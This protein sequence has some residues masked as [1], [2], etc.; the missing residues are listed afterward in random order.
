M[1][2]ADTAGIDVIEDAARA[3]RALYDGR[4]VGSLGRVGCFS[5]YPGK[6]VGAYG[7]GGAV[8]TDDDTIAADTSMFRDHGRIEGL[9]HGAVSY[10]E[11]LDGLRAAI[12]RTKLGHLEEWNSSRRRIAPQYSELLED[13]PAVFPVRPLEGTEPVHHL[14]VIRVEEGSRDEL[15]QYLFERGVMAGV[16]YKI[17]LHQTTALKG[18]GYQPGDFPV[19]EEA[20]GKI[21][22]LPIFPEMSVDQ[23]EYVINSVREYL[24]SI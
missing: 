20:A 4:R 14:Y 22:S 16:H 3:H 5:F 12:L 18:L 7:E 23:V 19:A 17:P 8:V 21:L 10:N 9:D 6:N 11:R 1:E 13:L 2:V 15:R 24:F